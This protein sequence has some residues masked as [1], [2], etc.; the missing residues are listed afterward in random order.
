MHVTIRSL[1]GLAFGL[2][3]LMGSTF[4][5]PPDANLYTTYYLNGNQVE[6]SVCGSTEQSGG[7]YGWRLVR[8]IQ[9][10]WS[11]NRR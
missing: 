10:A 2:F 1:V 6:L 8:T 5:K 9:P 3:L 4:A 11:S 7:C